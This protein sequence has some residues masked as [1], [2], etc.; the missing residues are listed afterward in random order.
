MITRLEKISNIRHWHFIYCL[1]DLEKIKGRVLDI[2]CSIGTKTAAI[3]KR[4]H[5]LEVVGLDKDVRALALFKKEHS[6]AGIKLVRGDAQALPFKKD[7]FEA[8]LMTD[9][10]EH[11]EK[12]ALAIKE[13]SRVLKKGGIFHL[14]VPLEGSLATFDGWLKLLFRV[15]LKKAPV[16][17]LHQFTLKDVK[18]ILAKSGFR[19]IQTRFSGHFLYQFFSLVY[20]CCVAIFNKGRYLHLSWKGRKSFSKKIIT[21]VREFGGWLT[22]LESLILKKIPGQTAHIILIKNG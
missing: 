15:N 18:K 1:K 7:E 16:G 11:L 14:V 3:K 4:R 21:K 22:S 17:H 5:D 13:V 9:V 19:I 2:G 8:V 12:P 10:L 6:L 20:Y